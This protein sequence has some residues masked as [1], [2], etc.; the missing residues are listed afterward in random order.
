MERTGSVKNKVTSVDLEEERK[1]CNF[2][3]TELYEF[4]VGGKEKAAIIKKNFEVMESDPRLQNTF[5]WYSMTREEQMENM[6]QKIKILW[7]L[8]KKKYF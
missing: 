4:I 5:E 7:D 3:Q 6:M 1:L 2:N 8:D